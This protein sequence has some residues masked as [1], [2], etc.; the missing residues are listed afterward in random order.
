MTAQWLRLRNERKPSSNGTYI[1][2]SNGVRLGVREYSHNG[3]KWE[4]WLKQ[5]VSQNAETIADG[6]ASEAEALGALDD[7]M[8]ESDFRQLQPPITA[9]ETTVANDEDEEEVK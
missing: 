1:D 7:F 6:Y 3:V 9:E 5:S 8:S 4:V 2:L